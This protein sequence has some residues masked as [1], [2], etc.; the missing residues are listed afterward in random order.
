[1][2]IALI[3]LAVLAA[4]PSAQAQVRHHPCQ[5]TRSQ[6]HRACRRV[7]TAAARWAGLI[8]KYW[9]RWLAR[10][11]H[12]HLAEAELHHAL[13]IV[14]RESNGRPRARNPYSGCSGLFQLL[15]VYSRGKF[16]LMNPVTNISLAGELFSRRGWQPWRL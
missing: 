12:R 3:L 2:A 14:W 10:I 1:M 16:D 15:P 11:Q 6:V 5:L 13:L 4:A 8:N 7:P 9:S